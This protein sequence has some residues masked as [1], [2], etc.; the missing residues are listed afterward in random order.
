LLYQWIGRPLCNITFSS[1]SNNRMSLSH[2]RTPCVK[3]PTFSTGMHAL[4]KS[5]PIRV[6]PKPKHHRHLQNVFLD[7]RGFPDQSNDY[8]HVLCVDGGPI[9]WK[10][11]HPQPDLDAPVNP[12]YYS[13]FIAKKHEDL[14]RKDMDLSHLDPTLQEKIYTIIPENWSMFDG[15]GVFVPVRNYECV[16]K[17]GSARPIA[18]KE[19]PLRQ[20]GNGDHAKMHCR[21]CQGWTHMADH[22]WEL[23]IQGIARAETPPGACEE[24]R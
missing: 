15:K 22:R 21:T 14:M 5:S 16:I 2:C 24:H 8:N 10:L 12:F 13:P 17:T 11:R 3:I 20:A 19:N 4:P 7:D 23:T 1:H 6:D 9:L 18:V